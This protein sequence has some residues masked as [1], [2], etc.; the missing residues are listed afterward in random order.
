MKDAIVY[1][2]QTNEEE[3]HYIDAIITAYDGLANVRRDYRLQ[4]GR[5][6]FKI[7]VGAGME[8]EFLELIDRLREV[9]AIGELI[10]GGEDEPVSAL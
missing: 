5:L 4:N 9:A 6:Y 10:K 7:Y 3:I 2:L 8:A 1:W